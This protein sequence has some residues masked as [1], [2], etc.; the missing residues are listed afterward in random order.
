MRNGQFVQVALSHM[1]IFGLDA[2]LTILQ[3]YKAAGALLNQLVCNIPRYIDSLLDYLFNAQ[4][5]PVTNKCAGL[6]Q[7]NRVKRE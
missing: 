2:K 4:K 7:E 3:T 1:K 5:S 6:S